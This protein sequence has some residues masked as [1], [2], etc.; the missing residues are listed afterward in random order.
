LIEVEAIERGAGNS[1]EALNYIGN[2]TFAAAKQGVG[3][4]SKR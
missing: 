3:N 4:Q 2:A 1:S